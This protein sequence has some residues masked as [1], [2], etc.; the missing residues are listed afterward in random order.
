ME[1]PSSTL[2]LF[3]IFTS[4]SLLSFPVFSQNA[5]NDIKWWCSRTPHPKPCEYFLTHMPNSSAPKTKSEF[6]KMAM[7]IAMDRA[8]RA[9]NK[10]MWLGS[11]CRNEREK[12]A[13]ADCLELYESTLIQLNRTLDPSVVCTDFDAQ[14]WLS[15]AL[16]NLETCTTGFME[17][18]VSDYMLPLMS[19]NVSKLISNTL[20]INKL[21]P[22]EEKFE[23]GFPKWV[24]AGD[25]KLLQ[26]SSPASQANL[27]VAQDGSGNFRTIKEAI[28]AASKQRKGSGR[29]IIY[30]KGGIY[31][32]NV[33]I[34]NNM[35]NLMLV[36]DGMRQTIVTG[37]KSVGGGSTTFDSATFAVVGGGF[38]AQGITFRNTAGPQNHQAVALRS[39]SDFSIFY[40][41]AFEGYQDTLYVHS[42]RQF[43]KE[44]YIY[45]TV[46]FIFGNAA[47]VFQ[48]CMILVRTPM[49][50][51]KNTVTAQGRTDPNQNTGISI[52]NSRVMAAPDFKPVQGSFQTFLGRPWKEYSRTVYLK[53]YLDSLI[54]PAGWLEWSGN[55][56]LNTLYY[57]EYRNIGPGSSTAS[58]VKW[59]GYHVITSPSEASKFTVGKFISGGSWLPSTG[60]PFA[61]GL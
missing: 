59:G 48:N 26:A 44:C 47:V 37:S 15:T 10:T 30:V 35:M 22:V 50:Q 51:Q 17:L 60:V 52:H 5:T 53:T 18:G 31:K 16:T 54:N 2:A 41:C 28:D 56:A 40:R 9:Q 12:A 19:N 7:K 27:V 23:D 21:P 36:G 43:Y 20:A 11:M 34:G 32:E 14:T 6:Q 57:G 42:Q 4:F 38:I 49:S 3:V 45:G 24:S 25:R 33:V 13:W 39:G 46:D 29:F 61:S 58:R 8:L 55:F 1:T